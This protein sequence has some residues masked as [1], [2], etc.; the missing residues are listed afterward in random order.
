MRVN[1][2]EHIL[3]KETTLL[4]FLEQMGFSVDRVAVERNG[5]ILAKKQVDSVILKND[6][7]LEIVSFVGG[8]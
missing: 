5:E 2:K 4:C 7:V 6:D 1:G 8:G 3:E